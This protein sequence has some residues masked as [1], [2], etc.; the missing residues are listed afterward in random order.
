MAVH[1]GEISELVERIETRLATKRR[2]VIAI[3]G[4]PGAGKSTLV[5][6]LISELTLKHIKAQAFP[7]DGYHYYRHELE[8]FEDPGEAK[9]RRGA[10]FTFNVDK[11]LAA[12][13]RLQCGETVWVPLFDHSVKD[14][15]EDDIEISAD[16]QVVLLEGNY[17]GLKDKPWDHIA[18]VTDELWLVS[19][20]TDLVRQ[21][22]IQ[23]HLASGIAAN[24]K[25]AVERADGLD[26]QNA[27]HVMANTREADVVVEMQ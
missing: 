5:A 21:R 19:A 13:D 4:I 14:P 20:P 8:E 16:V 27:L 18:L 6:L 10:P 25:E 26:W 7:Q 23:R 11:F 22:I 15:V 3:A 2:V 17:V 24:E 9:R 12:I 1:T